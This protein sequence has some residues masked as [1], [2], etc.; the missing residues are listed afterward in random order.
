MKEPIK[1]QPPTPIQAPVVTTKGQAFL[2]TVADEPPKKVSKL[3]ADNDS[4][5]EEQNVVPPK[6]ITPLVT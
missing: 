5:E 2:P 6:N 1:V 4:E 3:F